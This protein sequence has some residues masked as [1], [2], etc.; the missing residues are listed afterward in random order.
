MRLNFPFCE[1]FT[2]EAPFSQAPET[3]DLKKTPTF[4]SYFSLTCYDSLSLALYQD[5]LCLL[6]QE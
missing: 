1:A 2:R 6:K 3:K 4:M 5:F